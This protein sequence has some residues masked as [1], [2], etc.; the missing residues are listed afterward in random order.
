MAK[1]G[2][3]ILSLIGQFLA[4]LLGIIIIIQI[5][6]SLF[7]GTWEIENIILAIVIFN[8]TITFSIGGYLLSLNTKI[9]K[10]DKKIHGHVEW[11]KGKD[12]GNKKG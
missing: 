7:G 6:K 11:H 10:I 5:I 9:A 4:Y 12:S 2:G 8:L 3:E 1:D